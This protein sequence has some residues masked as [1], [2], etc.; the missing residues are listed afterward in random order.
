[1]AR[2]SDLLT[3]RSGVDAR[4]SSA[5]QLRVRGA[6]Y[7][8][9]GELLSGN[10]V[11]SGSKLTVPARSADPLTP[12]MGGGM[13]WLKQQSAA[14]SARSAP[15]AETPG[16]AQVRAGM[17]SNGLLP[18]SDPN[19]MG[20]N[21]ATNSGARPG[22]SPYRS[23]VQRGAAGAVAGVV[24]A[25][26]PDYAND[27]R[28]GFTPYGRVGKAAEVVNRAVASAPAARSFLAADKENTAAKAAIPAGDQP[29]DIAA[30][31]R[32]DVADS[33]LTAA[34][35]GLQTG[36]ASPRSQSEYDVAKQKFQDAQAQP[37]GAVG[38]VKPLE[39]GD[40]ELK[41]KVARTY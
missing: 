13:A 24:A 21:V 41:R 1:M 35:A 26:K 30:T 3:K 37:A 17:Q 39:V 2:Y 15:V 31:F 28:A 12:P 22:M 10:D 7:G 33:R 40:D 11:L 25:P 23:A 14:K 36:G 34:R 19:G 18:Q 29:V 38:A 20:N 8:L 16:Q 6:H 32:A 4:S 9:N 5:R 27:V